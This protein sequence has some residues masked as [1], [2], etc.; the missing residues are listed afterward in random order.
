M[1]FTGELTLEK[2]SHFSKV[3]SLPLLSP[4]TPESRQKYIE[5]KA[6]PYIEL[7]A[8]GSGY[9][10]EMKRTVGRRG[11]TAG[12]ADDGSGAKVLGSLPHSLGFLKDHLPKAVAKGLVPHATPQ[13]QLKQSKTETVLN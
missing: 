13:Y 6:G 11:K 2:L 12:D 10:R 9:R 8:A 5:L 4:Y 1:E 7:H 3:L